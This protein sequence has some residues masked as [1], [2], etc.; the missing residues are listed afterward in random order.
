MTTGRQLAHRPQRALSPGHRVGSGV[1]QRDTTTH[2]EWVQ[3]VSAVIAALVYITHLQDQM[4][5][6]L[7]TANASKSQIRDVKLWND[8]VN[9]TKKY[10][11]DWLITIDRR[12]EPLIDSIEAAGGVDE[13]ADPGYH[14]DY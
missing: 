1:A 6:G 3:N 9:A 7:T 4:L 5:A 13:V 14:A 10:I 12:L 2:G 11:R 8:H